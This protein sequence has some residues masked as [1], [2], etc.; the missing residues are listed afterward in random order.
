MFPFYGAEHRG[1]ACLCTQ[2][3]FFLERKGGYVR[4]SDMYEVFRDC[5]YAFGT[6][7]Q[8]GQLIVVFAISIFSTR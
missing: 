1:L 7:E 8:C 2:Y 6:C 3:C 5:M 4:V